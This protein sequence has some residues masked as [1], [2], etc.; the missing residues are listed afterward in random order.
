MTRSQGAPVAATFADKSSAE[1]CREQLKHDHFACWMVVTKSG[2]DD[3]RPVQDKIAAAVVSAQPASAREAHW[4]H[5]VAETSD[6]PLRAI[7]R[8]F[9]GERSLH[10][11][12]VEHGL[13][14]TEAAEIDEELCD[15]GAVIV[16]EAGSRTEEAASILSRGATY[17]IGSHG[18]RFE[19]YPSTTD[20][21]PGQGDPLDRGTGIG[22]SGGGLGATTG[23]WDQHG[24]QK[25][26][27]ANDISYERPPSD[28]TDDSGSPR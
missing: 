12:L 22:R 20:T 19:P 15:G 25:D 5:A 26:L 2:R 3:E 17:V 23:F 6:G 8:W 16:V 24:A 21:V 27:Q 28:E 14:D 11:S 1:V 4:A 13:S 18:E 10:G 9:S 7:G